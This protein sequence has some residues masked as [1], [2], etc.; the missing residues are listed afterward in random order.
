M[1]AQIARL[2]RVYFSSGETIVPTKHG[3]FRPAPNDGSKTYSCI[4]IDYE[5][6]GGMR[7]TR[8]ISIGAL[9]K[10]ETPDDTSMIVAYCHE[11]DDI[12]HFRPDRI[13]G[14]YDPETGRSLTKV[15]LAADP[16][17][18][19]MGSCATLAERMDKYPQA[20]RAAFGQTG[21]GLEQKG[22]FAALETTQKGERIACYRRRKT[23]APLKHSSFEM[24]YELRFVE[25]LASP[26]GPTQ[27]IAI[28]AWP[29]PWN[30]RRGK[31][32][33][34]TWDAIEPAMEAFLAQSEDAGS[35]IEPPDSH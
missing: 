18:F 33:I 32:L 4:T 11:K 27:R 16:A 1:L 29:Q 7:S 35:G 3:E 8:T 21:L 26:Q 22:W 9:T 2:I 24:G 23:G 5:S 34:G 15:V 20:L 13:F 10:G 28:K 6:E 17:A 31:G 25:Y 12:R 19:R 14:L 30:A